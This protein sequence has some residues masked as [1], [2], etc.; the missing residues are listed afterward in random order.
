[1]YTAISELWLSSLAQRQ[2]ELR[3]PGCILFKT[4]VSCLK[5]MHLQL[6]AVVRQVYAIVIAVAVVAA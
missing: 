4:G 3:S 2:Q 1:M 5:C 6:Y